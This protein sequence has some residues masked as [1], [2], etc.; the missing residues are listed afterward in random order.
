MKAFIYSLIVP[1]FVLLSF[2]PVHAQSINAFAGNHTAG[3]SGDNNAATDAQCY[4]PAGVAVD[5][6]GNVY[7]CEIGNSVIRKVS[8]S[9]IIT[10][11]AGTG[12]QG[13]SGNGGPATAAKINQPTSVAVDKFGNIFFTDDGNNMIRM[14]D[15][16]GIISTIVGT[17]VAG[18][19]DG[20][21]TAA[22]L[23]GPSGIAVDKNG[24]VFIADVYN[25]SIK[26][27]DTGVVT[28]ICGN[29]LPG[30]TGNGGSA[31]IAALSYP[32]GVA[33]DTIGNVYIVDQGNSSIRRI[34]A[35][36]I[37]NA[38]AGN[39]SFGYSGDG[40]LGYA[41]AL[42]TPTE[43]VVDHHQ[44]VYIADY[45]NH[46]VR[47]V[48]VGG[49][50]TTIAGN[51]TNGYSG[52]GG[53]A[54]AAQMAGPYGVA[55][56]NSNGKLYISDEVSNVIRVVNTNTTAINTPS[57]AQTLRIF[58]NPSGGDITVELPANGQGQLEIIDMAGRTIKS[59]SVTGAQTILCDIPSGNYFIK[60]TC[61]NEVYR[62]KLTV[63]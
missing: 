37:I 3:Y 17:G 62:D 18:N 51:H 20:L 50:I 19:A 35:A 33:V 31:S 46:V 38:Y 49:Y 16:A 7:F 63:L 32:K 36:G 40:G 13:F 52:D 2:N 48:T 12:V 59:I 4:A 57:T 61:G 39:G 56:D 53:P 28:T 27:L 9:G 54:I 25:H 21:A 44:N 55:F 30:S 41:A 10:T 34:N 8:P 42:N 15:P 60:V 5:N 11:V 29:G 22:E 23:N 43:V 45:G 24:S 58:P 1:A 47:R 26:R 14:I 6:A